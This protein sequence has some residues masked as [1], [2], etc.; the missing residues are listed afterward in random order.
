MESAS[1]KEVGQFLEE[2]FHDVVFVEAATHGKTGSGP[3]CAIHP[4]AQFLEPAF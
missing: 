2:D 1:R 3:P 4:F